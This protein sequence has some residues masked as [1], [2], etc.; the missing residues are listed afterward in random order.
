MG[1]DTILVRFPRR[2]GFYRVQVNRATAPAIDRLERSRHGFF[3]VVIECDEDLLWKHAEPAAGSL[4][5]LEE[6]LAE[7]GA[8]RSA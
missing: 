5:E 8:A 3:E 4:K 2:R 6:I 7:R 1:S